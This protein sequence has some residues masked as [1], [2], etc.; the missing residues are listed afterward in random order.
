MRR[1]TPLT[2]TLPVGLADRYASMRL[3]AASAYPLVFVV[4]II[5][6]VGMQVM[7]GRGSLAGD[8]R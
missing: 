7:A 6:P 5:P 4:M 1:P 8:R 3:E 2:K